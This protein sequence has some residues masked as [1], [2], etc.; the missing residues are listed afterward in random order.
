MFSGEIPVW[1]NAYCDCVKLDL[2]EIRARS[3]Y[4]DVINPNVSQQEPAIISSFS[5][6]F[7]FSPGRRGKK[8][9]NEDDA[10]L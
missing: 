5:V 4:L 3:R 10:N 2:D 7:Q 6:L 9:E 8:Y 1:G